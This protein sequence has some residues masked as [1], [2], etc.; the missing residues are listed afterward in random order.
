MHYK[1]NQ[2]DPNMWYKSAI[3]HAAAI[4]C[5]DLW[6]VFTTVVSLFFEF[7]IF[8][9]IK[10]NK[11]LIY[12]KNER[13][14]QASQSRPEGS[15]FWFHASSVGELRCALPI[16]KSIQ[17]YKNPPHILVTTSTLSA[18]QL[19][20]KE[21]IQIIH[22]FV[23]YDAPA[24]CYRF[25]AY[26]HPT[27]AIFIESEIWPTL[28]SQC[29]KMDIPLYLLNGRISPG[30]YKK[31]SH[32]KFFASFLLNCFTQISACDKTN[33]QRFNQ[34]GFKKNIKIENLKAVKNSFSHHTI[35]QSKLI[36]SHLQTRPV[37][38][39]ASV[40]EQEF[41]IMVEISN[42][43]LKKYPTLLTIIA[44]RHPHRRKS[45]L[46]Y[47]KDISLWHEEKMPTTHTKIWAIDCLGQLDLMMDIADCIFM[48]NSLARNP[49]GGHNPFEGIFLKKPLCTGPYIWNFQDIYSYFSPDVPIV[50]DKFELLEW[51]D[52]TINKPQTSRE[53]C[54]K[55]YNKAKTI[56]VN[57]EKIAEQFI[58]YSACI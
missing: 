30:S 36:K 21:N 52:K 11:E 39:A 20:T 22:Q 9:R 57:P 49:G 6:Y 53:I 5:L 33:A 27:I 3:S 31:W 32:L 37:F 55:N 43:L 7:L 28:I 50:K 48:G 41:E 40:H 56:S 19:L 10:N 34:L 58:S 18:Y 17:T 47:N 2:S 14:G 35:H 44:P 51:I 23:P 54:I 25:L 15:I 26:W 4:I 24:W 12:R 46:A 42:S 13:K 45:K 1:S 8:Y 38:L 16:I 29:H